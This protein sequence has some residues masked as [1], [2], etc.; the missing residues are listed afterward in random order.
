MAS[1]EDSGP[2]MTS[3]SV[4]DEIGLSEASEME[5]EQLGKYRLKRHLATGGMA[6][7][8]LAEQSGPEGFAKEI[9]IKRILPHLARDKDFTAMFLDEARLAANLNHPNIGQ[10]HELGEVDGNYYIA[11]EFID[12]ASL[13]QLL[14]AGTPIPADVAAR[15]VADVLQALDFAHESKDRRG[16]PLGLVHRDVTPSNIMVSVDGIVK[17]VDFGVAKAS[18]KGH[19]TQTGAV[20]GK[21]AYMAPEQVESQNIDRRADIFAIGIVFFELLTGE[22]PFGEDLAAVS[23]ILHEEP[24]S[25]Q[26]L[27]PTIPEPFA[28]VVMR[29]LRKDVAARY[30]TAHTMLLDIET[31]LRLQNSY[32]SPREIA[33]VVRMHR[34][35]PGAPAPPMAVADTGV[36]AADR[37]GELFAPQLHTEN[38]GLLATAAHLA[39]EP[40]GTE[41]AAAEVVPSPLATA[42]VAPASTPPGART[43]TLRKLAP[44]LAG[45]LVLFALSTA[46]IVVVSTGETTSALVTSDPRMVVLNDSPLVIDGSEPDALFEASGNMVVISSTPSTKI[47]KNDKFVGWTP[48]QTQLGAGRHR[49]ELEHDNERR[50]ADFNVAKAGVTRVDFDFAHLGEKKEA[51]KSKRQGKKRS[52]RSKIRGLF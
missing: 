29:A 13:E 43:V 17:L 46:A 7:I 6:E 10:I 20:K 45:A 48:H 27:D 39:V 41:P 1:V 35:A 4:E 21:F 36:F 40:A 19:K 47:F 26:E 33:Q 51:P 32:A 9:V 2:G 11:M 22:R 14:S 5:G 16:K 31:A 18:S 37:S 8:Y 28:R 52:L 12:G 15:I 42:V 50:S 24:P 34:G 30:P 3:V 38:I 44:L 25:P 23:R 49:I